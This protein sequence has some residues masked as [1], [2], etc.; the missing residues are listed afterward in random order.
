MEAK[1]ISLGHHDMPRDSK[2]GYTMTLSCDTLM[3][4]NSRH[5]T[6]PRADLLTASIIYCNSKHKAVL[7]NG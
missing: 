2:L 5:V 3:T 4:V 6:G 1:R 7:E